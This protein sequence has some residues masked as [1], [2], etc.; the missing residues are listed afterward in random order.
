MI[1]LGTICFPFGNYFTKR[2]IKTVAPLSLLFLRS[3]LAGLILAPIS[4]YWEGTAGL[5]QLAASPPRIWWI[6][7]SAVVLTMFISKVLWYDGLKRVTMVKAISF[8]GL[9][10]ALT[11]LFAMPLLGEIPTVQQIAG[12]VLT[13]VGMWVL[14]RRR[15]EKPGNY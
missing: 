1:I 14:T 13:M 3:F 15:V 6:I 4:L 5:A 2:A 9:T 7:L 12:L 11:V 8:L 10:P